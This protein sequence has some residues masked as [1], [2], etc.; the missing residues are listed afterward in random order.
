[1]KDLA[2]AMDVDFPTLVVEQGESSAMVISKRK[3]DEFEDDLQLR[4]YRVL[5]DLRRFAQ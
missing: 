1:M 4:F 5:P 3:S 2:N